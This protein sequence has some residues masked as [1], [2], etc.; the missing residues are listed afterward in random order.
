MTSSRGQRPQQ[1]PEQSEFE[2]DDRDHGEADQQQRA[3]RVQEAVRHRTEFVP[4]TQAHM[5]L[6]GDSGLR[7]SIATTRGAA[8]VFPNDA[9]AITSANGRRRRQTAAAQTARK[10]SGWT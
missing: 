4:R 5:R 10:P 2:D 8:C 1:H 9:L 6:T 3:D 7:S